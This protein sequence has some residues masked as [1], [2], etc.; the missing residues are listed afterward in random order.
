MFHPHSATKL[1]LSVALVCKNSAATIGLTLQR[2]APL[3]SEIIALDSGSTDGT[4]DLLR[5]HGATIH[6]VQWQGFIKTKQAAL[7][8]CAQPWILCV[9]SDES[10]EPDLIDSLRQVITADGLGLDGYTLNRKVWYAGRFLQHAW[11]PEPRLRLVRRNCARWTGLDPHDQ[12]TLTN[13]NART[14]HL[15]GDLRHDSISTFTDFLA[16]QCAHGKTMAASM[17]AQG[18]TSNYFKLV[19]SPP[20]VFAKQ[21]ILKRAFLDGYRGWLAAAAAATAA[22]AKHAALI[23]LQNAPSEKSTPPGR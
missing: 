5:A 15:T 20:A 22:L 9:D 10:P 4:L 18:R 1:P 2:L 13:P 23:E 11:Q 12:L 21:I 3:A 16:K 6:Q 14:G 19:T 17:H 7:Q 8:A